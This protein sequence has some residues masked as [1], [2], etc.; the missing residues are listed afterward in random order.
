[1]H[2]KLRVASLL[3]AVLLPFGG[4]HA[5]STVDGLAPASMRAELARELLAR[6]QPVVVA[7]YGADA[8]G[9]AERMQSTLASADMGNLEL[10]ASAATFEQM[11]AAL[12]GGAAGGAAD[13][14]SRPAALGQPG[15]DL[16]YTPVTPC[17]IADTRVVGGPIAASSTRSF[18][19]Y[20]T[21][22]FSAQGGGM[23]DC[24][25]PENASAIT[26]KL[27]AVRPPVDG[28]LTAFPF[29][30]TQP[31]A[32]S[33]NYTQ[34]LISSDESH[35]RLCRPACASGFNVFSFGES[36]V[37]IDVTGYFAEP[38]AT[39]LD[40]TV[41]QQAGNLDLLGGLQARSVNCPV[42]YSAT[43][44][45]CGGPLGIGISNSQPLLSGG[46]PVGWRCDL[47]GS[48]LSVISYQVSATCC[49]IPGR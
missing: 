31:L 3:L 33:L 49:R 14:G 34:G 22:D 28:F 29:G 48:L 40:C 44:G 20:T 18:A 1:M 42:G 13:G 6:W 24:D 46:A 23:G 17:R 43:G 21:T 7:R 19:A 39:A 4:V 41:A 8:A 11:N 25:L 35:V 47:V 32:S 38:E 45:G 12:L 9:W 27:T 15:V 26:V 30:E 5:A 37:V 36:D 2:S 16:V 10:A